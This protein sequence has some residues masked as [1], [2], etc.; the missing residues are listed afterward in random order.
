M[1]Q[2]IIEQILQ[3][4]VITESRPVI[5]TS[6]AYFVPMKVSINNQ[7]KYVWVVSQFNDDTYL[8]GNICSPI[9]L[10]NNSSELTRKEE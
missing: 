5:Y 10:T 4:E 8:E 6:G 3:G 1:K 2:I 9:V 7:D